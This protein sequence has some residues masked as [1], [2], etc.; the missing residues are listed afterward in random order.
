MTAEGTKYITH[1]APP[2]RQGTGG[3]SCITTEGAYGMTRVREG[4]YRPWRGAAFA[5]AALIAGSLGSVPALAEEWP[6]EGVPLVQAAADKD[7]A[8]ELGANP[9]DDDSS[10]AGASKDEDDKKAEVEQVASGTWG[11]CPWELDSE[12]TLTIH[13]GKGK[14]IIEKQKNGDRRRVS[15]WAKWRKDVKAVR[16]VAEDGK[17][18]V[19]PADSRRLFD[20]FAKLASADLSGMDSSKV[21]TMY[22]LFNGCKS[23]ADLDIS[24]WSTAK[25]RD[26]QY[27]FCGCASLT[28]V[29][30]SGWDTSNVTDMGDLFFGCSSLEQVD[31]SKWNTAKVKDMDYLF[32]GCA[33]L[34]ELDVSG[35]DT[36]QV[37]QM[38]DAAVGAGMFNGCASLETLDVS[39]WDTAQVTDMGH[40]FC[41]CSSLAELDV[42][43][44]NTAQVTDMQGLFSGCSAVGALDVS[45]WDT[46]QVTD[47]SH[48][49]S[50]CTALAE[51]AVSG[52]NTAQVK[53][54]AYVFSGCAG[55]KSLDLSGWD[56]AQAKDM[57]GMFY[58]CEL[59]EY[60]CGEGLVSPGGDYS[61]PTSTSGEWWSEKEGVWLWKSGVSERVGI[62]DSYTSQQKGVGNI[63]SVELVEESCTYTGLEQRPIPLVKCGVKALSSH[64]D[65]LV[66]YEDNTDVGTATVKVM[67]AGDYKG[68]KSATFKI[69]GDL[70]RQG[71]ITP[72]KA[73]RYRGSGKAVKPKPQVSFAGTVL[74]EGTDYTVSY[75]DNTPTLADGESSEATVIVAGKGRYKG[76]ASA[77]YT[78]EYRK[79]TWECPD[80][81]ALGTRADVKLTNG[82]RIR[83]KKDDKWAKRN[84]ILWTAAPSTKFNRI[85]AKSVGKTTLYLLD[86]DGHE[87][88]SKEIE[89]YAPKATASGTTGSYLPTGLSSFWR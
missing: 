7:E 33:A 48:L 46:A 85:R 89:V 70:S 11:T 10:D 51:L 74:K 42:S 68:S 15:P 5:T 69:V 1:E 36:S 77:H 6:G 18:I 72:L 37:E 60:R 81:L 21:K 34:K 49:F 55:L 56:S 78:I 73:R 61:A 20:G 76:I 2:L 9:S 3:A 52:W 45:G 31:V 87:V 65:Y 57:D 79:P 64:D 88:E 26:M 13:P 82:G 84:D 62:A 66:T 8:V 43:G 59:D 50:D 41:G 17:K 40:L 67:G 86:V 30:V 54:M 28:S 32:G 83:V 27:L 4:A 12:G 39:G 38:G 80:K 16:A 63:T 75:V 71:K 24:G 35:W 53:S 58:G 19:L 22:C 29:D 14:T 25:V 23:L 47:M 44:W